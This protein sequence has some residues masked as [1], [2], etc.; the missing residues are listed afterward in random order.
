M[1]NDK[2]LYPE[3][4]K[5]PDTQQ[6]PESH[7]QAPGSD[8]IIELT[9][10]VEEGTDPLESEASD[11]PL[12][13]QEA[14]DHHRTEPAHDAASGGIDPLPGV[15]E[16]TEE[17]KDPVSKEPF[18]A[19]ESSDFKFENSPSFGATD[20]EASPEPS[21]ERLDDVLADMETDA[22]GFDE[23]E[24]ILADLEK[25]EPEVQK[26]PVEQQDEFLSGREEP[27]ETQKPEDVL[28]FLE[29]K[30]AARETPEEIT[31]TPEIPGISEDRM[32]I[33]L[34]EVIQET[35]ERAVRETVSDVAEKVIREAI[36]TLKE[37]IAISEP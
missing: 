34:T 8:E 31:E 10:V 16:K 20:T 11:P 36:E 26:T 25:D 33:L 5:T 35:V 17:I 1:S 28:A 7:S 22:S 15:S 18:S 19:L 4:E 13:D 27:D 14:P 29:G 23:P 37:S 30:D 9:D 2:D 3:G 32:K 12:L 6:D 21:N 24:D